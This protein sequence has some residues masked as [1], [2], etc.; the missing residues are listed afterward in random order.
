MM[1]RNAFWAVLCLM[2]CQFCFATLQ[3]KITYSAQQL[4][5]TQWAY[6]YQ[7]ENLAIEAG[8]R[9]FTI[10]FD[11]RYYSNLVIASGAGLGLTW[12][13]IV[14]QPNP[15]AASNGAFDALAT[16]L[17]ILTGESVGGFSVKFDWNGQGVPGS[18]SYEIINPTTFDTTDTGYTILVPEPATLLLLGLGVIAVMKRKRGK[19]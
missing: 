16:G 7:V 10:W 9:E 1:M 8:I 18:Q 13:Q 6:S 12:D 2:L 4:N 17:A 11:Q 19:V 3:T 5:E 14:W 15:S